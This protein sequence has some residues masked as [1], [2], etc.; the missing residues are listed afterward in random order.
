[1]AV[2][3][4]K[5]LMNYAKNVKPGD[6]EFERFAT[7]LDQNLAVKAHYCSPLAETDADPQYCWDRCS[8]KYRC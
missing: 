5:F 7:F 4:Q 1:M 6:K 2:G 3:E 8:A